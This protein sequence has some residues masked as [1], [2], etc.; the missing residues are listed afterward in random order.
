[1]ER[2]NS[3]KQWSRGWETSLGNIRGRC[4]Q[5]KLHNNLSADLDVVGET[6]G[7]GWKES[8]AQFSC[9][10]VRKCLGLFFSP[11]RIDRNHREKMSP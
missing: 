9:S 4:Q 6:A 7:R 10:P 1:M 3:R 5:S 2:I 8:C 11:L